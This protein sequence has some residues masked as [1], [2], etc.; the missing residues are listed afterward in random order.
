MFIFSRV[1]VVEKTMIGQIKSHSLQIVS[2]MKELDSLS[3]KT[4]RVYDAIATLTELLYIPNPCVKRCNCIL[5]LTSS[6]ESERRR[7]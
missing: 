7:S 5:L 3:A 4:R 2:V 6:N 1:V